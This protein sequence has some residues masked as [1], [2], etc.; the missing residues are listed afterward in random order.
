MKEL[1]PNEYGHIGQHN[2]VWN[3][4]RHIVAELH[5]RGGK[6][7]ISELQTIVMGNKSYGSQTDF[8]VTLQGMLNAGDLS[9]SFETPHGWMD[10]YFTLNQNEHILQVIEEL[11]N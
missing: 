6:V 9:P 5:S 8:S 3:L 1:N 4:K 10:T 7:T 11:T 2:R